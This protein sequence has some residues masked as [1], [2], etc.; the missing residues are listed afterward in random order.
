MYWFLGNDPVNFVDPYGLYSWMEFGDDAANF[1]AGFGDTITFG[2]TAWIRDQW[3]KK[4]WGD[5]FE[6]V[7]PC[8]DSYSAGKWSGYAWDIGMTW[9]GGLYGGA[10]SVF[11]SGKGSMA[12]AMKLGTNLEKTPIGAIM[13]RFGDKIPYH[14][15]K[16]AS[17]TFAG[18]VK[19]TAIKVG[20][21]Q[22]NIW[23]T[24]EKPILN[25]RNI[26]ITYV[27]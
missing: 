11:W 2:G 6:S 16:A 23:R 13:N 27:P 12:R 26:S 1:S 19:G 5:E 8:S 10:K 7:D 22:G 18:N 21:R 3:N 17:A 20:V 24:I 4:I 25:W 9:T 14:I 15:W